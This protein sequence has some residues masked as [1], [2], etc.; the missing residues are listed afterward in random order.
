MLLTEDGS[1]AYEP[2]LVACRRAVTARLAE[3]KAWARSEA[4]IILYLPRCA[5]WP[6]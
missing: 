1:F 2:A 3:G 5:P 4:P 6:G